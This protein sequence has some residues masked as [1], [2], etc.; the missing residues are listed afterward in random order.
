MQTDEKYFGKGY[1][2]VVTKALLKNIAESGDDIYV[3]FFEHNIQSRSLFEKL[4]F[5]RIGEIHYILNK[6]K[7]REE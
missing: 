2:K 7:T 4:G 5:K 3:G 6:V 1:A